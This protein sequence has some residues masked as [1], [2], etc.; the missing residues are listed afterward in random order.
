VQP[1]AALAMNVV[2]ALAQWFPG[3]AAGP[4]AAL[5]QILRETGVDP[6][7]LAAAAAAAPGAMAGCAVT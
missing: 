2:K 6:E 5:A 1:D 3:H 4:D 7:A